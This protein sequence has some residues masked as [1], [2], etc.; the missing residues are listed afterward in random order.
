[1]IV[2]PYLQAHHAHLR[3]EYP[4]I[5][6]GQDILLRYPGGLRQRQLELSYSEHQ[7]L[8]HCLGDIGG[9]SLPDNFQ[10]QP[11]KNLKR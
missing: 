2:P 9:F 7:Y 10:F 3:Y 4:N 5:A 6:M 8:V 1:M 11:A